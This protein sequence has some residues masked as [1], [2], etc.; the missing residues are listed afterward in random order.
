MLI[1]KERNMIKALPYLED[2]V[3]RSTKVRREDLYELSYAYYQGQPADK[4]N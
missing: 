3:K 4:S 1:L 2:Y